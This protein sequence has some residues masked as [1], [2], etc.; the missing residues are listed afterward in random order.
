[1]I[2]DKIWKLT[3]VVRV[4]LDP[5][6][7][8]IHRDNQLSLDVCSYSHQTLVSTNSYS[9]KQMN[10]SL[11]EQFFKVPLTQIYRICVYV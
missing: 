4:E 3:N 11:N 8:H 7:P 1:M 10:L 5:D 2:V 9:Y 6:G